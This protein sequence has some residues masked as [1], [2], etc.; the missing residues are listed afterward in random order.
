MVQT[1]YFEIHRAP[2]ELLLPSAKISAQNGRIG[3]AAQQVSLK[4]LGGFQNKFQTTFYHGLRTHNEGINQ[5]YMKN[6]ADAA[7]KICCRIPKNLGLGLNFRSCSEGYFLS[8]HLQSVLF[9]IIFNLKNDIFKTRD[10]SPLIERVLA[11]VIFTRSID[12][13]Q[14]WKKKFCIEIKA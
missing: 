6:W 11:G 13:I 5:R 14:D 3:L 2:S 4:G 8:G 12:F 7:D 1:F 9:T 10:F